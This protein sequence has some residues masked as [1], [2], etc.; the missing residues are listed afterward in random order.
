LAAEAGEWTV[1]ASLSRQLEAVEGSGAT[2]RV[3]DGGKSARGG[4]R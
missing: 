4:S 3:L 1:V 2:L